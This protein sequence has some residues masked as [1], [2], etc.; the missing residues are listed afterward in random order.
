M[1][2]LTIVIVADDSFRLLEKAGSSFPTAT[3]AVLI[4]VPVLVLIAT[5]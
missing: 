3:L 4:N 1:P 5:M 2:L